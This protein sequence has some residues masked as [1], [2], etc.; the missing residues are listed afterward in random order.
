MISGCAAD[1]GDVTAQITDATKSWVVNEWADGILQITSGNG[2]YR[3][4][5]IISNTADTLTVQQNEVAGDV[6]S[7]YTIC[8]TQQYSNAF[9]RYAYEL[10]EIQVGDSYEIGTGDDENGFGDYWNKT[11]TKMQLFDNKLFVSTGLN[12][13]YGAQVWYT[14]D[15]DNWTVTEPTNSFGNFH[16]KTG[17]PDSQKPVSTSI[18][19]LASASVSG[20]EVLYAGG[21]GTS[22]ATSE[23]DLGG[24]SR[25]AKLTDFGWEFIV[26]ANVD[27]NDSGTNENGFGDGMGCTLLTGNFLPWSLTSFKD[28][29]MAGIQTLVGARVLYSTNG[30]SEDGSWFYSVGG[31]SALPAGFDGVINGGIPTMYQNVAVNL[32]PFEDYLYAGLVATYAP[33]GG[34]TEE[35]LTGSHIWKTSD[36]IAW[37]QVTVDGFGDDHVV[38]F[39]AFTPFAEELYVSASKGASASTE[40]LGGAELYRLISGTPEDIDA[41]GI[42]NIEDNCPQKPNGPE[43][44]ICTA[45]TIVNNPCRTSDDCGAGGFCSMNQEDTDGDGLGDACNENLHHFYPAM[46]EA[47]DAMVSDSMV[48]VRTVEVEEW[49]EDSNY[50]YA[51][52]PNNVDPTVGFIIYPGA[53]LDP[54]A[55]A[56]AAHAI[57]AQGFL[58]VIVKM[59]DDVAV[60]GHKRANEIMSEYP[61]I[62]RWSIGGHSLGGSF[63]CAYAKEFTDKLAGVILWASYPSQSFRLDDTELKAISIY[64]TNDGHPETIEASAEHLPAGAEFVKIE[65]GNHTQFGYYDTSP[66]AY[67]EGDN[68]ADITREE[69]QAQVIQATVVFLEQFNMSPPTSAIP[70]LSEWGM[71][72][73]MII[74]LGIGVVTLLRRR[75]V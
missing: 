44:G 15:G 22:G 42:L 4:F 11:I 40:S 64:G 36:G 38:G 9:P 61:G 6:G 54:R 50:Y 27:E 30:S 71:I 47:L 35:Y 7:E 1:D 21:A 20:I 60:K 56:P 68:P 16:T 33:E 75:M 31:D 3:R 66:M 28:K 72:I 2:S 5:D 34:A 46:Q 59:P 62:K 69:Q 17:Y 48:T 45:G 57:A 58:T 14:E 39:E 65:G 37:Q 10:G 49:E 18:S 53:W 26:D 23:V 70:T 63:S 12:Y 41:D 74:I 51:F 25:V 32:S 67:Q 55:Y 73:F 52:E 13:E 29:L 19:S 8:G 24:C 43:L